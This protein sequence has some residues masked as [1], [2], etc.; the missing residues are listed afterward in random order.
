LT[1]LEAIVRGLVAQRS[2]SDCKKTAMTSAECDDVTMTSLKDV[3]LQTL[4]CNHLPLGLSDRGACT[5]LYNCCLKQR[6]NEQYSN[7]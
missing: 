7:I 5:S 2:L 3:Y 6:N 4:P 1:E